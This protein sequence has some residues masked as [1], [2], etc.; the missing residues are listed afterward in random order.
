[1]PV[2]ARNPNKSSTCSTSAGRYC[3]RKVFRFSLSPELNAASQA[4]A[5]FSACDGATAFCAAIKVQRTSSSVD[6]HRKRFR[7]VRIIAMLL[8]SRSFRLPTTFA[9]S[10]VSGIRCARRIDRAFEWLEVSQ[11][12]LQPPVLGMVVVPHAERDVEGVAGQQFCHLHTFGHVP[13]QGVE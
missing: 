5:C 6:N 2:I 12:Q 9:S 13:A 10:G 8:V 1:P 3:W 11:R 7:T 4:F